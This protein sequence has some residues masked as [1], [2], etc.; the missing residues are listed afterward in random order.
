[1]FLSVPEQH[2]QFVPETGVHNPTVL[3]HSIVRLPYFMFEAGSELGRDVLQL[4]RPLAEK[5]KLP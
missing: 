3:Q 5:L 4:G 2:S 1:M